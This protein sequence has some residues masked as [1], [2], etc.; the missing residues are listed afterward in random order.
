MPIYSPVL[1]YSRLMALQ[2]SLKYKVILILALL[3]KNDLMYPCDFSS[4]CFFLTSEMC[5]G[6]FIPLEEKI[7]W[8]Q[9]HL[10]IDLSS[11]I[12][13][14]SFIFSSLTTSLK[15]NPTL[16]CT[17]THIADSHAGLQTSAKTLGSRNI[18]LF[19]PPLPSLCLF[20]YHL[21]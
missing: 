13:S 12:F 21:T 17:W 15:K 4:L 11:A 3:Y 5:I 19:G 14:S 16:F 20:G 1:Y 18:G 6:Q 2:I 9:H 10:S 8:N 7:H